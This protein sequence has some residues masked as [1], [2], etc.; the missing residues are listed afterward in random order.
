[1][2]ESESNQPTTRAEIL[3]V[4][5]LGVIEAAMIAGVALHERGLWPGPEVMLPVYHVLWGV[6]WL[7]GMTVLGLRFGRERRASLVT[8]IALQVAAV[9]LFTVKVDWLGLAVWAGLGGVALPLFLDAARE[10]APLKHR[11]P[12]L[13]L[14][15]VIPMAAG[16]VTALGGPDAGDLLMLVFCLFALL[17]PHTVALYPE[18]QQYVCLSERADAG[19]WSRHPWLNR[20]LKTAG[21]ALALWVVWLVVQTV[22][23]YRGLT[24]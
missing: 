10:R 17:T 13:A 7:P 5:V 23:L 4:I 24:P 18:L 2:M 8:G 9:A 12:R 6:F 19:W 14:L 11:L 22:V 1:M 20:G 16:G 15:L 21:V 3:F